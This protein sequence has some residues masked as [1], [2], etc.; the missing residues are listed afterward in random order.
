MTR[1]VERRTGS[2]LLREA[3][4]PGDSGAMLEV[5][6]HYDSEKQTVEEFERLNASW[7][8]PDPRLRLVVE[9]ERG[10]IVGTSHCRRRESMTDGLFFLNASVSPIATGRGIGSELLR[11]N[12]EFAWGLGCRRLT[13]F[14]AESDPR[15][16]GFAERRSYVLGR[17]LF[18]SVL[19]LSEVPSG[20]I[21]EA[22]DRVS[23]FGVEITSLADV[24]FD[25]ATARKLFELSHE[26][27]KDEP[28][29]VEFGLQTYEDFDRTVFQ[30]AWFDPKSVLIAVA[31][32]QWVGMHTFGLDPQNTIANVTVDFTGVLKEFRGRGIATALKLQGVR[33]AAQFGGTKILTHNDSQNAPMLAVNKKLGYVARP[34][35]L[36]MDKHRPND[37]KEDK[38]K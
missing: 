19:C 30:A 13:A 9:D 22:L 37:Q 11:V 35:W 23:R 27:D 29:T 8:A 32:G 28:A 21:D 34:G 31:D 14:V 3:Q 24:G 38:P 7:R 4:V 18:E 10:D 33:L 16:R 1:C 17:H 5:S 12:E 6:N 25:I 36:M 26:C 20:K 15:A 2:Y